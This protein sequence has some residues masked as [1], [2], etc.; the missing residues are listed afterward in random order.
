MTIKVFV[1]CAAN[2]EDAESQAVLE[3]TLRKHTKQNVAIYWMRLSRDPASPFYSDLDKGAGWNTS[4]WA[5]P[6]SGFRWAVPEL[7]DFKGRALYI[8]SDMIFMADVQELFDQPINGVALI[9]GGNR[10]CV[11]LWDCAAAVSF[12]LPLCEL[13]RIAAQH[14]LMRSSIAKVSSVFQGNW[15]CLDGEKLHL[16]DIKLLHYTSMPHQPHLNRARVRLANKGLKH[17]FDGIVTTHW[18]QDVIDLFERELAAAEAAG[19]S[20]ANYCDEVV[21]PLF[22]SYTKRSVAGLGRVTPSWGR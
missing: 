16:N 11:M 2:H 9:K 21:F 5:T 18:R 13:Q 10:S 3:Y 1:G 15:N 14:N 12:V 20:V 22:G 4:K 8:D 6:F 17:W 7:C 19:Y